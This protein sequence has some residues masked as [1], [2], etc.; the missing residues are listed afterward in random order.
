MK[1]SYLLL[2]AIIGALVGC[3]S[4]YLLSAKARENQTAAVSSETG[5]VSLP[6][7]SPK[8]QEIK[9]EV[10]GQKQ[11]PVDEVN[12]PGKIDLNPNR[13]A[14]VAL[15]SAGKITRVLVHLGDFVSQGQPV[16]ALQSPDAEAA[17][18]TELQARA[19][20]TQA[21]S[22]LIKAKSDFE[23]QSDLLEQGA[24]AKK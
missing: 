1:I 19:G 6:T 21:Q 7:D 20:V 10:V 2:L 14:H 9:V 5:R 24:V 17:M 15:P 3:K 11:V 16:I 18:S 12:A 22:A 13:V 8:L 23:R 4:D